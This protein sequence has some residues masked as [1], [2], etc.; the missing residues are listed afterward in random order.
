MGWAIGALVFV[1]AGITWLV[2]SGRFGE[3]PELVDDRPV[4][5]IPTGDFAPD[6]IA[7]L[8]FATVPRGYRPSE[9]RRSLNQIAARLRS[10]SELTAD[11]VRETSFEVVSFGWSSA[12]VDEVLERLSGQVETLENTSTG[13]EAPSCGRMDTD[14][15]P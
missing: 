1:V 10:E 5:R 8:H 13:T 12:Q 15:C 14:T 9:V 3:Q 11:Q 6:D 4:P 2:A 7:A